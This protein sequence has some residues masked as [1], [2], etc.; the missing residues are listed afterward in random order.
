[1][2]A[3][4]RLP[5]PDRTA[6]PVREIAPGLFHWTA[7]HPEQRIVVSSYY[8]EPSRV[9]IDPMVPDDGLGWFETRPPEHILITN[10]YHSRGSAAF[11]EAFGCP[12]GCHRAGLEHVRE[13][14]AAESFEHGAVLA[15]GIEALAVP[16]QAPD[17]TALHVPDGGG[18]LT[19]ADILI[20]EGDGPL[21]Y[22]P[23]GW[24]GDDP[25]ATRRRVVEAGRALL[26]REFRHLFL[27]HGE[28]I[29]D[30]GKEALRAFL[31]R[32]S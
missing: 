3:E 6:S 23:D 18:G 27:T 15:G 24:Y 25:P 28:P 1:M 21:G 9:L 12:V 16:G 8:V 11:V 32:E 22:A 7:F 31:E 19:F 2:S 26:E 10:R 5:E 20:R 29:V 17:E 14:V 13:R 4:T 30:E